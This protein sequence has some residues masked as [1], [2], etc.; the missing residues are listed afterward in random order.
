MGVR[1]THVPATPPPL[2]GMTV[3]DC[4]QVVAGPMVAMLLGD[5]GADVIKVEHP[6]GGDPLRVFGRSRGDVPLFWQFLSRNKRSITLALNTA[7]GQDLFRRL[8]TTVRP[9]VIVESFRPGTFERWGLDYQTL[10]GLHPGVVLVRISGFGQTGPYRGRPG[11]G[12]LAEAMSGLASMMGQPDGPPTLPPIPLAD[13]VAALYATI[14]ALLALRERD[15]RGDGVGQVVDASLL[16]SLFSLL[17]NQLVEFDQLG[18]VARRDGNRAPTS[19]PRNLY[20]TA[21]GAWIAIAAPTRRTV[22]RL[23]RTIGRPELLGDPRFGTNEARLRN[24]DELDEIVTAWTSR[25]RLESA[26][27]ALVAAEV[28]VA[29]V[30]DIGQLA[31]D[32]HLL[33]RETVTTISTPELGTVRVPGVLPRLSATPGS[34]R[35]AAPRLGDANRDIY[36]DLLGLTDADLAA[37]REAGVV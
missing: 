11:F 15:S 32:A 33:E 10:R 16:E 23:L 28:P 35:L 2:A 36:C 27:A 22:D 31:T 6:E 20:P 30:T 4:G 34:I 5:F 14:G 17:G 24:V 13:S 3:F 25:H 21:D 26:M 19:A 7:Q 18:V 9:D 8:V 29:P 37:L 12:T 1:V